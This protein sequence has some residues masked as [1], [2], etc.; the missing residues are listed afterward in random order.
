VKKLAIVLLLVV[1][2][3][4]REVRVG[5]VPD[6][7]AAGAATAREAVQRFLAT[8]KAQDVQ[9][10]SN[11]WGSSAGPARTTMGKEELEMR[12]IYLMRCLR[13]DSYMILT[14][15]PA[16]GGERI[17]GVQLK[18]GTLTAVSNFTSTPAQGRWFLREFQAEPL[19]P[20]CT[21]K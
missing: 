14:E 7:N 21:S 2:G 4:R 19:N 16:A 8:A 10:M 20:I 18:R 12:I 6:V 13:H 17:F 11:I 15:T 5:S 1:A 3:C 9:A